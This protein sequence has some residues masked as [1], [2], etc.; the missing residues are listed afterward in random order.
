MHFVHLTVNSRTNF[1]DP[2]KETFVGVYAVEDID[3][4]RH[5]VAYACEEIR[6]KNWIVPAKRTEALD[7]ELAQRGYCH[8]ARVETFFAPLF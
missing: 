3:A 8:K 1:G 5:S 6:K 4:F 7:L 2:A